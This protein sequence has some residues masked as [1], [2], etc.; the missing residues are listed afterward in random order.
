MTREQARAILAHL[1]LIRHYAEGGD[2]GHRMHNHR[3]EFLYT[4]PA[5]GICLGNLRTDST[6]YVRVKPRFVFD[7]ANGSPVR[8]PRAFPERIA[9][10][11]IIDGG[12]A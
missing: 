1:D 7:R 8:R 9:E 4:S 6:N 12:A 10:H 11:E 2:V 5:R 3:G